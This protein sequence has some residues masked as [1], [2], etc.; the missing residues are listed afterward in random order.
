MTETLVLACIILAAWLL[1]CCLLLALLL[2]PRARSRIQGLWPLMLSEAGILFAATAP[3]LLPLPFLGI[4]LS[5]AALRIG[6]ESGKVN[7][8]PSN[9]NGGLFGAGLLL[10][11]CFLAW[12]SGPLHALPALALATLSAILLFLLSVRGPGLGW[13]RSFMLFPALPFTALVFVARWSDAAAICVL[14]LLLVEVFDSFSLLGGR[15]FGKHLLFPRLS[16]R[17]TWEGLLTGV[18]AVALSALA[19]SPVLGTAWPTMIAIAATTTLGA[20]IGDLTASAA[21]R[22]AGVKDYPAVLAVQGGLLDIYDAWI[23][24]APLAAA[25]AV[26]LR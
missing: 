23:V 18:V 14:A 19:L 25:V 4:A 21:K 10:A 20:L 12:F 22:R 5:A 2:V 13:L 1:G 16:P 6:Y 17:K 15:L 7:G 24:A 26:L 11:C 8:G 9:P 3:W